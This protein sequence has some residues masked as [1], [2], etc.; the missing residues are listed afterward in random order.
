V[1]YLGKLVEVGPSESIY[2]S[3]AHHYT[4]GLIATVPV[5]NPVVQRQRTRVGIRGELPSPVN[6]PS[7]CR[8]RTRCPAAQD[9]CA[10]EEPPMRPFGEGHWAACHF[11]LA[12]PLSSL[13]GQAQRVAA[14]AG[15]SRTTEL[16]ATGVPVAR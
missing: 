13:A 9:V 11:P 3:P 2:A 15:G 14:D 4:A 1:M 5:P 16:P 8:F 12:A 7:G 10:Q 6:P